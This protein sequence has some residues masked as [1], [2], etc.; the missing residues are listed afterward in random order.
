MALIIDTGSDPWLIRHESCEKLCREIVKELNQRN[1]LP[2]T[3]IKFSELS[4]AVRIKLKQFNTEINELS[5]VLTS[6]NSLTSEEEERRERLLEGLQSKYVQLENMH[7][8]SG[9]AAPEGSSGNWFDQ[10]DSD[11]PLLGDEENVSVSN[12]Q[13]QQRQLLADQERGL[14]NFSDIISKQKNMA[15]AINTEIDLHNEILDDIGTRMD[16]TNVNINQETSRVR[17]ISNRDNTCGYWIVILILLICIV[18]V[19]LA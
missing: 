4:A 2:K 15:L 9:I 16:S 5:S 19:A 12:L 3:S 1:A 18:G 8:T 17:L 11:V 14:E 7:R 10:D 6:L 13:E